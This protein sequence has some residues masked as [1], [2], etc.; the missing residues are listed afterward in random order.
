[1]MTFYPFW[2]PDHLKAMAK[3]EQA[4]LRVGSLRWPEGGRIH[5]GRD[6]LSPALHGHREFVCLIGSDEGHATGML[7]SIKMELEGRD[8]LLEEFFVKIRTLGPPIK[9]NRPCGKPDNS[10]NFLRRLT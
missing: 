9:T 8:L 6:R 5:P 10:A 7:E 4:A 3:I 2:S 1:M